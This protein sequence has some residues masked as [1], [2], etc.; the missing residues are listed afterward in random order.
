[1]ITLNL[2]A[3]TKEQTI[4]KEHLENNVSKTLADKINNGVKVEKDGRTLIN[5]KDLTSFLNYAYEEA[6][7]QAE[8][9][10][11][12]ACIDHQTVFGWAVHFFEEE[13]II[14]TLYNENG[15][16]Y[17]PIKSVAKNTT[18]PISIPT[19]KPKQQMDIFDLMTE[20]AD[21]N[22]NRQEI[23]STATIS[24]NQIVIDEHEVETITIDESEVEFASYDEPEAY[25]DW[26][27]D[28]MQLELKAEH[29]DNLRAEMQELAAIGGWIKV[30]DCDE[31]IPKMP[32]KQVSEPQGL[33]QINNTEYVDS[34]GIVYGTEEVSNS[35]LSVLSAIFG[36]MLVVR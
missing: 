4:L 9:N 32:P 27:E 6:K 16:E 5:K 26:T 22:N 19:P 34:D 11:K 24:N 7:N 10:A 23:E 14:G 20:Q 15:T 12:F 36:D 8:K 31:I 18:T 2:I 21:T 29:E 25:E 30:E 3:T 17:K 1:M 28:E 35:I 33:V 13:S